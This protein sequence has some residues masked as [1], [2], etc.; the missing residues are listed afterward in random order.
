MTA[1]EMMSS[2]IVTYAVAF[3]VPFALCFGLARAGHARAAWRLPIGI[4]VLTLAIV[5]LGLFLGT[6]VETGPS[7]ALGV[8]LL[9][10]PAILGGALGILLGRRR[11]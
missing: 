9:S 5:G 7:A 1:G 10:L 2:G 11:A 3:L 6:E 8:G 4:L